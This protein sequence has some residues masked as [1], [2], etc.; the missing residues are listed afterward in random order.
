METKSIDRGSAW[1]FVSHCYEHNHEEWDE[2]L[3]NAE[4]E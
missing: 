3:D 2:D 1:Q 4:V